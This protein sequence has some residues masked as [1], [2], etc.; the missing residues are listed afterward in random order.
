MSAETTPLTTDTAPSEKNKF[1]IAAVNG[2]AVYVV[3]YYFISALHQFAKIALSHRFSLRGSWDP[4]KIVYTMADGEWWRLAIIA[5]NGIGPVVCL[6][7]GFAAFQWYWRRARAKRGVFKLVLIWAAFHGFNAFF[8]ALLA[9][10]FTQSGFWYVPS[11]VFELGNVVN[12]LLALV[13]GIIQLALGYFAAI[14]FLQAHDSKTV[15]RYQ[16][17]QRMVL[18]TLII[19]WAV[20][21][22]L[23]MLAKLPYINIQ[24]VLR[25]VMMGLLVTPTALGCMNELF[26]STVRKPQPTDF[27]WGYIV[28]GILMAA[29]WY[30]F[31]SPPVH[32]G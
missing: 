31:L 21:S 10:T 1:L 32:F 17:R 4:S 18:S 22:V 30:M 25:L 3:T 20:G 12:V 13:A 11:W 7:A 23:I 5:I 28:L 29:S 27:T 15:M 8:G 9:D 26:E 2:T 16:H 6:L 19:P 14:P 24:E